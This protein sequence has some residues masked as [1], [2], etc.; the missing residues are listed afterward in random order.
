MR[1][2]QYITVLRKPVDERFQ[3]SRRDENLLLRVTDFII[4]GLWK[5]ICLSY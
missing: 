5:N 1:N 4:L 2:K 3:K